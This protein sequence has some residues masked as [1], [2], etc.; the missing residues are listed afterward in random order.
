LSREQTRE[1]A[2]HIIRASSRLESVIAAM[3]DASQLEVSGLQLM[4][5]STHLEPILR[6]VVADY[7]SALLRRSL[8]LEMEG[9]DSLPSLQG[10]Y[11]R[12]VQAFAN[13]IGNAIKYTPD[14][15]TITIQGAV[16]SGDGGSEFIEVVIADTGIGINPQFHQLIFE[17][18]FRIGDPELHSTGATKYQ[19]AGPGLG[20]HIAKGVFEA[21]GGS[22]WVE[23]EGEDEKR[24]PGSRFHVILPLVPP[25]W[26]DRG[27]L[28]ALA[29]QVERLSPATPT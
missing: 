1:I 4:L 28:P 24:L 10:D 11:K 27:G 17:K 20:L 13:L 5:M 23:S 26:Q 21:H 14:H 6:A 2:G 25:W 29:E 22:I 18:F 16:I 9:V 3:L 7:S 15:G 12:L 8:L 19:G